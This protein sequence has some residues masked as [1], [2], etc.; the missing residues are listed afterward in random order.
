[1]PP[2]LVEKAPS[3][4]VGQQLYV[5]GRLRL[6]RFKTED[7][8]IG[9]EIITKAYQIYV[10]DIDDKTGPTTG[11]SQTD[12]F[13]EKKNVTTPLSNHMNKAQIFSQ[14]SFPVINKVKF[15]SFCLFSN[16]FSLLV[17]H[18]NSIVVKF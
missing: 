3:I 16:Y 8:S 5:F 6:E 12:D 13:T 17:N 9:S 15:S 2:S 7:G 11:I 4:V 10:C 1:M 18:K 14:I